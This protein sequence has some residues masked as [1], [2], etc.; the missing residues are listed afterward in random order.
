[1]E[2]EEDRVE[3]MMGLVNALTE[4]TKWTKQTLCNLASSNLT[5]TRGRIS[6]MDEAPGIFATGGG[7]NSGNYVF[8]YSMYFVV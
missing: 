8:V 4:W 6:A 3:D 1:M 5:M 2:D 7:Q